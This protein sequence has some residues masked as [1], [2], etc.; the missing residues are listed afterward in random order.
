MKSEA[1]QYRT[2]TV[3]IVL[4]LIFLQTGTARVEAETQSISEFVTWSVPQDWQAVL[5]TELNEYLANRQNTMIPALGIKGNTTGLFLFTYFDK[6]EVI[7]VISVTMHPGRTLKFGEQ[8]VAWV[9][10]NLE[11]LYSEASGVR[12]RAFLIEEGRI[13]G[14]RAFKII[15]VYRWRTNTVKVEQ[16]LVPGA[17]RLFAV[18]YTNLENKFP[19]FYPAFE[20]FIGSLTISSTSLQFDWLDSLMNAAVTI[21]FVVFVLGGTYFVYSIRPGKGGGDEVSNS[22]PF[23]R[24]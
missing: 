6:A 11:R 8:G 7:P 3:L 12:F 16:Y 4:L 18:T 2:A 5:D 20:E 9:R 14:Q 24:K 22:N 21:I 10:N 23:M 15:G 17:G 13:G 1:K 19:Q